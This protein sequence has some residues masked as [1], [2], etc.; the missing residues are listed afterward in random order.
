[1]RIDSGRESFVDDR[2]NLRFGFRL[3]RGFLGGLDT[4]RHEAPVFTVEIDQIS[5]CESKTQRFPD[6]GL[7]S[8]ARSRRFCGELRG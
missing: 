5:V 8:S 4:F 2:S 1:M 6:C 7:E 3:P